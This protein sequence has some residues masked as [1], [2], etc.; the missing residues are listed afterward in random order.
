MKAFNIDIIKDHYR[1]GIDNLS[2]DFFKPCLSYSKVYR[3]AVAYFSTNTL[4]EWAD[5][6]KDILNN[7]IKIYLL[8]SPNLSHDDL[9]LFKDLN[10]EQ[11]LNYIKRYSTEYFK[12]LEIYRLKGDLKKWRVDFFSYIIANDIMKIKFA[13]PESAD[14]TSLFHE[15][16]GIFDLLNGDKIAF[17]GSANETMGGYIRNYESIDVYRSW[18]ISDNSRVMNKENQFDE[19]WNNKAL[20]LIVSEPSE[21]ILNKIKAY[22]FEYDSAPVKP[23]F[24]EPTEEYNRNYSKLE[25]SLWPHQKKALSIFLQ[26]KCGILEMATGT[27]KTRTALSIMENLFINNKIDGVVITVEGTDLLKQWRDEVDKWNF[28][29]NNHY[30][31]Y[32]HFDSNHELGKFMRN[33]KYSILIISRLQL[34]KVFSDKSTLEKYSIFIIHDEVHGFGSPAHVSNLKNH[35][36]TFIYKLGLSA[37]PDREYD[38]I[39]NKFIENE[40]GPII[41][42]FDIKDAI[43]NN[44]LCE[45]NYTPI[46]YQLSVDDKKRIKNIRSKYNLFDKKGIVYDINDLYRDLSMV[47]KTAEYKITAFKELVSKKPSVLKSCIIFSATM[48]YA[49]QTLH[50]IQNATYK[51]RTYF[52]GEDSSHLISF[53]KSEIDCLLTCHKLSQGID[54]PSLENVI[55]LSS[56]RAKLETIQRIGRCLRKDFN[57]VRKKANVYDFICYRDNKIIDVDHERMM[58]LNQLSK[59][60]NNSNGQHS[61]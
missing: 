33:P 13:F 5:I 50:Y 28:L 37:T 25:D 12:I 47:Y 20:G 43:E 58:W 9:N 14:L 11:R 39:G 2:S 3:R 7:N 21:E 51:Y 31:I 57:N 27:G 55:L 40:I 38:K 52:S 15:K 36:K 24:N 30:K 18:I 35:H 60:K 44:I 61:S 8:I 23:S 48:N 19:A 17:T 53:A 59:T 49:E 16:I 22:S 54:I 56:D 32:S 4:L 10:T 42:K 45:F 26:K 29:Q 1:S 34:T 6:Y 41:F 46:K